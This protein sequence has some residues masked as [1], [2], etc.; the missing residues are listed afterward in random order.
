[1][2]ICGI[3]TTQ[4]GPPVDPAT[5]DAMTGVMSMGRNWHSQSVREHPIG[6]AEAAPTC[7]VSLWRSP[8]A[9]VV[10]DADLV[11]LPE[12]RNFLGSEYAGANP[13]EAVGRIYLKEGVRLLSRL[14]GSFSI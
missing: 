11:N 14:R 13:A 6:F 3:V 9:E 12:L 1:M 7:T 10:C 5:L 2:G 4:G 8:R